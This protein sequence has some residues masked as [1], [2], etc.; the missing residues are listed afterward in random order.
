MHPE[1]LSRREVSDMLRVLDK[2]PKLPPVTD[3]VATQPTLLPGDNGR[4]PAEQGGGIDHR[5][6]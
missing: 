2:T 4:A 6:F 3:P 5:N 1:D